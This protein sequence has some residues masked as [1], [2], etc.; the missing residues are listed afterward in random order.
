MSLKPMA[1][2]AALAC[3]SISGVCG[4]AQDGRFPSKPIHIVVANGAGGGLARLLGQKLFERLGQ[5]VV[6]ENKP[7]ANAML[8]AQ[9]VIKSPADGH[10]L[11]MG[12]I[13]MLTV[14]PAVGR[15]S[16]L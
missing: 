2:L 15:K 10:T 6:V 8:A 13:G 7:D 9:H 4:L 11:L 14:N 1:F 16:I 12:A 3:A 5:P